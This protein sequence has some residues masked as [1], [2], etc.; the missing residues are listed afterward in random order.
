[1]AGAFGYEMEHY[2]ISLAMG[3]RRLFPAVRRQA[4]STLLAASGTSCREQIRD[5]TG[6]QAKHPA[7]ILRD[8]LVSQ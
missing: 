6:R 1:M 7:E 2:D 8:A 5:G 3:E 4:T